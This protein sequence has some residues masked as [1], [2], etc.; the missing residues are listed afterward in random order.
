[1]LIVEIPMK[2]HSY[3][4]PGAFIW[5][6][7]LRIEIQGSNYYALSDYRVGIYKGIFHL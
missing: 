2:T 1:M 6:E 7:E 4:P 5:I 3:S